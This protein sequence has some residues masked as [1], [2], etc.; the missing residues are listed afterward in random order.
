M[1]PWLFSK[2]NPFLP[3]P[4]FL[5]TVQKKKIKLC[6]NYIKWQDQKLQTTICYYI[7][8]PHFL[9][10]VWMKDAKMHFHLKIKLY[11]YGTENTGPQWISV[12]TF[13]SFLWSQ[14]DHPHRTSIAVR[15]A[16]TSLDSLAK[17]TES[18]Y[19]WWLILGAQSNFP[20][21]QLEMG[22]FRFT[23]F[24]KIFTHSMKPGPKRK[25]LGKKVIF[26]FHFCKAYK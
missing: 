16:Q 3:I 2:W 26:D 21:V 13:P 18:S 9:S 24:D 6:K 8:H 20:K 4:V 25:A 10:S 19:Y 14:A 7:W 22:G 12:G 17:E 23:K 11:R 5:H 1:I 15:G